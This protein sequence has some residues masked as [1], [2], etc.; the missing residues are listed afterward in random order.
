MSYRT[1]R[2]S[3]VNCTLVLRRLAGLVSVQRRCR[4]R[5]E[6]RPLANHLHKYA[7]RARPGNQMP[8]EREPNRFST[9]QDPGGTYASLKAEPRALRDRRQQI[10][11]EYQRRLETGLG[12]DEPIQAPARPDQ[13]EPPRRRF[14]VR[15]AA[16]RR[17]HP[18]L[19]LFG[20]LLLAALAIG[21]YHL[22]R[23]FGSYES[24]DNAQVN[25]HLNPVASRINGTVVAVHFVNNQSV[26]VNQTLV[27]LDP[28]DYQV[29]LEQAE[30]NL[31]QAQGLL[32][33]EHPNVPIT[34]TT[35]ATT[36]ATAQSDV[37]SAQAALTAA[38]HD[39]DSAIADLRQAEATNIQAQ[40]DEARYRQLVVKDEVS[41][42]LYDARLA[43]ARAQAQ[44]VASRRAAA[45]SAQKLI[46]Q[47]QAALD[48]AR[49]RETQALQNA[50]RELAV[51]QATVRSRAGAVVQARAQRDTAAL[52]LSY[53]KI[54]APVAGVVGNKNVE[55]G[56]RIQP[57]QQLLVITQINDFWVDAN[58]KETQI[59][60]MRPGQ[61]ATIH[62]D[63][64]R[65]DFSG[66][67]ENMPGATGAQFSLLPPE[68]AT[69][70][71]VKVVQR[72][73]VRI[74]FDKGQPG[75]ERLRPGMS[76]EPKVW[77]K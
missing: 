3:R 36:L 11:H 38:Q 54:L 41:R 32:A 17:K 14:R 7:G 43:A 21:G 55:V 64:L 60:R 24:T 16:Y 27:E 1:F 26:V 70:N 68:N 45:D 33:A 39:Y 13:K 72:L 5:V 31:K 65:Q 53:T 50:P 44:M 28:R 40:A 56:Q 9:Q 18:L 22:W 15:P 6:I 23:Y 75:M 58:F 20:L 57:G 34:E 47:R 66:Y 51:R 69:G 76:V 67:V 62:V 4:P 59:H 8:V 42:E 2:P 12:E 73:P 52:Q 63:A 46:V 25:G 35:N 37:S 29:A 48:Q 61:R 10:A 71:F 30:G 77:L 49:S 19:F 74:H